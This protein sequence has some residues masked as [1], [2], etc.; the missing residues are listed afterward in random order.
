MPILETERLYLRPFRIKDAEHLY[1]MNTDPEVIKYTGD[2]PFKDVLEAQVFVQNYISTVYHNPDTTSETGLGRLTIVRKSDEAF[3][4]W[5]GLK[6]NPEGRE[7]DLGYRL[8]K[9][10]WRQGYASE[11]AQAC[12]TYAFETLK[13]PYIIARTHF[14]N[15]ASQTLLDNQGFSY[16]KTIT[17]HDMP[18][19]LYHLKN[20]AYQLKE[21]SAKETWPVRHPVLR[22]G[23][24][25][26]DVYMEADEQSSTFHLGMFYNGTIIGVASFMDDSHPDF[27]GSQY[28]LRG[29]AVLPEYRRKGIAELI[30]KRG[31]MLLKE[32][33]KTLLWFNARVVALQFYKNLG[34]TID[35]TQ[36]DIP[37]VGPHYRMKKQLV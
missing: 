28:R 37:K 3:I 25:L 35:G 8:Y 17:H 29:M 7:V 10:H 30:L 24:P 4:G 26:E 22:K 13:L 32:K 34:Y 14:D 12:I 20:D 2:A 15:I 18:T 9:K 36:F 16:I 23:R 11:S 5:C 31:E 27:T 19:R 6:Y 21:I 1:L 33:G